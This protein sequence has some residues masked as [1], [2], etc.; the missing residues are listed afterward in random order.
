MAENSN[1]TEQELQWLEE[2]Q[3]VER[4]EGSAMLARQ[5]IDALSDLLGHGHSGGCCGG[6]A[7]H[8]CCGKHHAEN[9]DK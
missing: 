4:F 2:A 9:T 7:G 6:K 5:Q 8:T 3:D 1:V